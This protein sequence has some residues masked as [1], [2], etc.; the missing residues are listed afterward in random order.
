MPPFSSVAGR[1]M[2]RNSRWNRAKTDG[3]SSIIRLSWLAPS[4]LWVQL[5]E[6]VIENG[7]RI[8]HRAPLRHAQRVDRDVDFQHGGWAPGDFREGTRGRRAASKA[9]C[10]QRSLT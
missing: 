4:A 5:Y 10:M 1:H 7:K 2:R 9:L 6:P 8:V 3:L